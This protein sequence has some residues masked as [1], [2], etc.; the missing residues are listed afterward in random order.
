MDYVQLGKTD[1]MVSPVCV[2]AMSF[3]QPETM[4][5]WTLELRT[6]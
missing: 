1:I 5:D 6:L 2:G 4:H 3:G